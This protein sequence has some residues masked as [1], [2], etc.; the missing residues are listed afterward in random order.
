MEESDWDLSSDVAMVT[1]P[2]LKGSAQAEKE[3]RCVCVWVLCAYIAFK[4]DFITPRTHAQ[5]G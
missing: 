4:L 3:I 2:G 1:T 5:Q